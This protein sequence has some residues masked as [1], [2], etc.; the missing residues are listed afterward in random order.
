MTENLKFALNSVTRQVH[1]NRTKIGEKC[2][3]DILSH[4]K[5]MW[6]G[7]KYFKKS[8]GIKNYLKTPSN[9][10][11]ELDEFSHS[12]IISDVSLDVKA[13]KQT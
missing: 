8:H 10:K 9:K 4:F 7:L 1:F 12:G 13:S 5:T 3:C 6:S 11:I 2:K